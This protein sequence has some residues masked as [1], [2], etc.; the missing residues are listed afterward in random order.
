MNKEKELIKNLLEHV[1]FLERFKDRY[2]E[3]HFT[4]Y[5]EDSNY[6]QMVCYHTCYEDLIQFI[7]EEVENYGN[8]N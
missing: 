7:K 4:D 2:L 5:E 3:N 6:V 1:D 8:E